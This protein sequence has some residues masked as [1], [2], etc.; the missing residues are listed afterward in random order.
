[1]G[2]AGGG[3]SSTLHPPPKYPPPRKTLRLPSPRPPHP[4]PAPEG[5]ET[6]NSFSILLVQVQW[7]WAGLYLPYIAFN[8]T[9][10]T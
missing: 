1:M 5:L 7:G 10:A 6:I 8:Y 4:I 2:G 9:L 3:L